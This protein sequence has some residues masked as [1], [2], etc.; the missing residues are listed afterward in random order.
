MEAVTLEP[1]LGLD[2]VH[3]D[4][5]T[6]R[7]MALTFRRYVE[8]IKYGQR[9]STE[10]A[11]QKAE[12]YGPD[13][14]HYVRTAPS[15]ELTWWALEGLPDEEYEAKWQ[16]I[17][18]EAR[19][20]LDNGIA[21]CE[22]LEGVT[23]SGPWHRAQILA[24]RQTL[25]EEWQPRGGAELQLID[26]L[27]QVYLLQQQWIKTLCDRMNIQNFDELGYTKDGRIKKNAPRLS[28]AEAIEQAM[29][30][31]ERFNRM[32]LRTLRALRDLRRYSTSIQI[33]NPGQ[34]NIGEKQINIEGGT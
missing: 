12:D 21:C 16:E 4:Q 20:D 7:R 10:E 28:E 9:C 11:I 6:A 29:T 14:A 17:K 34:V 33:N 23:G 24:A 22:A 3:Q 13:H 15:E 1:L 30:L 5:A 2:T 26:T 25:I 27:V 8:A 19:D 18:Q 31:I 32:Y